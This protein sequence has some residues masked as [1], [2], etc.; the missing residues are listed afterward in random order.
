MEEVRE[1]AGDAAD[2]LTVDL[3]RKTYDVVATVTFTTDGVGETHVDFDEDAPKGFDN[4]YRYTLVT[5]LEGNVLEGTWKDDKEHPDF[6]WVPYNNPR[7]SSDGNSENPFL[8]YGSV[9]DALG[10]DI[11]RK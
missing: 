6:A 5:D 10:E 9:L 11:E 4:T 8:E 3:G 7:S 2:K 1:V